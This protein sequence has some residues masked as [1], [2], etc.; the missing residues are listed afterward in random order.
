MSKGR[1]TQKISISRWV[2]NTLSF[3]LFIYFAYHLVHGEK[4][5]FAWRGLQQKVTVAE[6]QLEQKQG[7][8]IALENRV[9]RLRP[10]S[11]DL[12]MLDERSRVVLGFARPREFVVIE[13]N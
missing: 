3:G 12:D 2:M 5:Y 10:E 1:K 9:K 7:E 8:R 4:G 13:A 6:V 11:L